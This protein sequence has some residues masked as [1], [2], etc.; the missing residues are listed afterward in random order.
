MGRTHQLS[1]SHVEFEVPLR[2][3]NGNVK[4]ADGKTGLELSGEV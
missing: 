3:S 2:Q 1:V 4:E